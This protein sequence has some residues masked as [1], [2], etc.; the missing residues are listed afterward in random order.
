MCELIQMA[1]LVAYAGLKA[2]LG[3]PT[4]GAYLRN[5]LVDYAAQSWRRRIDLTEACLTATDTLF[6]PSAL[7]HIR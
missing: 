7:V 6:G 4:L 1:D 2:H 3:D 5:D